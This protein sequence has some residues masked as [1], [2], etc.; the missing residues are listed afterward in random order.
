MTRETYR[1]I[2]AAVAEAREL[3]RAASGVIPPAGSVWLVK[4]GKAV[5]RRVRHVYPSVDGDI[6]VVWDN[7]DALS[8]GQNEM[9]LKGFK[10]WIRHHQAVVVE[11]PA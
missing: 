1:R 4:S 10:R 5:P 8:D 11:Y 6:M 9:Q 3:A 2:S 7:P